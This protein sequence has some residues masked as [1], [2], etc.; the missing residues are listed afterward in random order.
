MELLFNLL[1]V[2]LVHASTL[3]SGFFGTLTTG[4]NIFVGIIKWAALLWVLVKVAI[5]GF[6]ISTQAKSSADAIT[7]VKNEGVA[8]AIGLF[9]VMTAF[10]IHGALKDTMNQIVTN[11]SSNG[12]TVN[13][14]TSD[15]A[16]N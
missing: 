4:A 7:L 5:L 13:W 10:L 15:T 1:P 16:L 12:T 2:E 8:L 9:I 3:N 14:G 6:K 11:G